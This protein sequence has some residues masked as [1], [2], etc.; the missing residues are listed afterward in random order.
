MLR[1]GRL[2]APSVN[3]ASAIAAARY[4]RMVVV[5]SM[6]VRLLIH[7]LHRAGNDRSDGADEGEDGLRGGRIAEERLESSFAE[8]ASEDGGN[9]QER[10]DIGRG[11]VFHEV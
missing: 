3:A 6:W 11:N 2:Q 7:A 1:V 8:G 4:L 10:S 9:G 5:L